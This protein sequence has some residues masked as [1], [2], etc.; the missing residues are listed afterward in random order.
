MGKVEWREDA[1]GDKYQV[2]ITGSIE[3]VQLNGYRYFIPKGIY[4]SVPQAIA[5]VIA[6]SQQQTLNAGS[7]ISLNRID[8]A[9][10]RPFNEIL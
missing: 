1:K 6:Q 5:E 7:N 10:G 3:T 8:P 4:T 2:H 9:T